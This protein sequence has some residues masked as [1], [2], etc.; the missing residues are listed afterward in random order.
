M[1]HPINRR[2]GLPPHSHGAARTATTESPSQ[3]CAALRRF[4]THCHS[5]ATVAQDH[6]HIESKSRTQ[7]RFHYDSTITRTGT[8]PLHSPADL[9]IS[10]HACILVRPSH[11]GVRSQVLDSDSAARKPSHSAYLTF[12]ANPT[13]FDLS[14]PHS[15][16]PSAMSEA[17]RDAESGAS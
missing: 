12:A 3:P 1:F 8:R 4:T 5:L 17:E 6:V 7:L 15:C 10:I 14:F 16:S 9:R 11:H 2:L 13:V